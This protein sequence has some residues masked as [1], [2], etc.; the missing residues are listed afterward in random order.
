MGD[1]KS[2]VLQRL[3]AVASTVD[4]LRRARLLAGLRPDKYVRMAG[5]CCREGATNTVGIAMS[6]QRCGDRAAIIDE[7]GTLTF[8]ELDERANALAAALQRLPRGTP[9]MVGIMCRNHRGF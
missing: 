1:S 2:Q 4:T 8:R 7:F 9:H 3:Q 6:A 5:A